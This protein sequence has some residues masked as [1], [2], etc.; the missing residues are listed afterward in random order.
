MVAHYKPDVN[1]NRNGTAL[2]AWFSFALFV[3]VFAAV[4]LFTYGHNGAAARIAP[5][6]DTLSVMPHGGGGAS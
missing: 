4:L 3:S 5:V 6:R 2:P 1:P